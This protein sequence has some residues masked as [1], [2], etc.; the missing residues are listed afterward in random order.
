MPTLQYTFPQNDSSFGTFR[1]CCFVKMSKQTEAF[2]KKE[3]KLKK[4]KNKGEDITV[5]KEDW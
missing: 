3:D 1:V 2:I 4:I 5:C